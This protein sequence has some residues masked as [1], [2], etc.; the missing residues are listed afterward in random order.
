MHSTGTFIMRDG[1]AL[2]MQAWLPDLAEPDSIVLGLHGFNDHSSAFAGAGAWLSEQGM[3][4]YSYDQRGFGRNPDA[5]HWPGDAALVQDATC[6]LNQIRALWPQKPLFLFGESMGGAVALCLLAQTEKIHVDGAILSAP[7][8]W[9]RASMP[10]TYRAFLFVMNRLFPKKTLNTRTSRIR[11]SDNP[12]TLAYWKNDP[13]VIRDVRIDALHG[14]TA[15]MDKAWSVCP[16][17][18]TPLLWLHGKHDPVIPLKAVQAAMCV[19]PAQ[20]CKIVVYPEGWH[21]L[22]RDT[23]RAGVLRDITHWIKNI[24]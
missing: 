4:L 17:V 7:A 11:P 21:L 24:T 19:M 14:V 22:F 5:G 16:T 10:R 15:L 12:D 18:T 8:V 23:C 9:S 6:I 2:P 20:Y 1:K 13:F 3:A